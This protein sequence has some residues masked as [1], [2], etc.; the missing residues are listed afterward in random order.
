MFDPWVCDNLKTNYMIIDHSKINK[1]SDY[2][3]EI[4][5]TYRKAMR[6]PAR[7]FATEALL[8][9]IEQDRTLEQLLN[10]TTLPGIVGQALAMPDAHEGY[11]FPIG[12]VAAIIYPGG[13]VSPGG[14]GYD[15]NCGVRLLKSQLEAKTIFTQIKR[16]ADDLYQTIPA[17][18]GEAGEFKLDKAGLDNVLRLGVTALVQQGYG[19]QQDQE[20]IESRGCLISAD[21]RVASEIAK[22]RGLD[23]IG[24][25]GAGNHFIEIDQIAEIYDESTAKAYGIFKNQITVLIH[26][27][28]RGL[29]HQ[30]ATDYIKIMMKVMPKYGINIPDRELVCAPIE[31]PEGQ[32]YLKAMAAAA[33]FAWANRQMIT[34]LT[35]QAW[36]RI[37]GESGGE[38][39]ILYDVAHN[40]A[41]IEEHEINGQKQSVLVHRKGATRAFPAGHP[42]IPEQY[43]S[44]GQP[45]IIPGSMGTASYILCGN[46][47]SMRQTFGTVCHGAGRR[48]SRR[49]AIESISG[50][51]LLAD[52]EAKGITVKTDS[53]KGL[54]EEAP[55]AYTD[56]DQV[57]E[58]IHQAGLAS[59]VA[60]LKP[61]AVIKG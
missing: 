45:V 32:N 17:G 41:K 34:H 44:I 56:V 15:I 48:M 23:Q 25:L 9:D 53:I 26:T 13:V 38:L 7:I 57:V 5:V 6:V 59:K 50:Q 24:T 33:N 61:L 47:Q 36:R 43:R 14:I 35:R 30:V 2:L 49:A 8:K 52:L 54:A 4:P 10:M 58:V 28:S 19:E 18:V 20:Y 3:Y 27:G 29:G 12:G 55:Q 60:K 1:L 39:K 42:D 51:K 16:L 11:G 22:K 21:P 31:S 40:I 46:A 37:L